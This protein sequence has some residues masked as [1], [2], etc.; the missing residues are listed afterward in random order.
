MSSTA[1]EQLWEAYINDFK[2]AF[3][4]DD[5]SE[6]R[7]I[8]DEAFTDAEEYFEIDFRLLASTHSLAASYCISDKE[9][10]ARALYARFIELREKV[11]GP[12]DPDVAE[13]LERVA[14]L[15]LDSYKKSKLSVAI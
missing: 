5:L 10:D 8:L 7:R 2:R 6:A 11:L 1:H 9:T 15:Q 12:E 13:S 4:N 3:K 14:I